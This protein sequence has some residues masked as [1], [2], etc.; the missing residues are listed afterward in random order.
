MRPATSGLVCRDQ[1]KKTSL[2]L[3]D[4]TSIAHSHR[5][6][7]WSGDEYGQLGPGTTFY[8]KKKNH[9]KC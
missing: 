2:G 7:S 5:N 3:F 6:R 9:E 4:E 1:H 8:E